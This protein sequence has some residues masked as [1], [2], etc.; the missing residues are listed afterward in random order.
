M[1]LS[2]RDAKS[3]RNAESQACARLFFESGG[4]LPGFGANRE[5]EFAVIS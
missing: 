2:L 1:F 4:R 5:G 3:L